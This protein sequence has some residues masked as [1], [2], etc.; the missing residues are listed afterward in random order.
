M[1]MRTLT[2]FISSLLGHTI[3]VRGKNFDPFS[4]VRRSTLFPLPSDVG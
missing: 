4:F 1:E 2:H 3:Q